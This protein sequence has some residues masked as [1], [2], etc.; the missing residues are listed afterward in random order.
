MQKKDRS[1]KKACEEI[2]LEPP[3]KKVSE[4]LLLHSGIIVVLS[5]K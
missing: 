3:H 1:T 2:L 4:I 5:N